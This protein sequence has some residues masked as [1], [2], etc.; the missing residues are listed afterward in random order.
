MQESSFLMPLSQKVAL[1]PLEEWNQIKNKIKTEPKEIVTV[2]AP[3]TEENLINVATPQVKKEA[4]PVEN[5]QNQN[6]EMKKNLQ[7]KKPSNKQR[8]KTS[9]KIS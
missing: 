1:V 5:N 2:N 4:P 3:L 8:K 9:T 6:G 7:S